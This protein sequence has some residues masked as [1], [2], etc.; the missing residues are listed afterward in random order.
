MAVFVVTMTI[1]GPQHFHA[2]GDCDIRGDGG[3]VQRRAARH[4]RLGRG[5]QGRGRGH[6]DGQ[7]G[8]H[9][10]RRARGRQGAGLVSDTLFSIFFLVS[11]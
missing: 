4:P 6:Q 9:P 1:S 7:R 3:Q 8:L 5:E 10:P 11:S 2:G